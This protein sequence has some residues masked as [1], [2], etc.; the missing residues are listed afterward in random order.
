MIPVLRGLVILKRSV[1]APLGALEEPEWKAHRR[2]DPRPI[3]GG[4]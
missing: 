3:D 2:G 4:A 1:L